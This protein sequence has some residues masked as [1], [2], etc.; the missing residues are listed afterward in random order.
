[1]LECLTETTKR[2]AKA[3]YI[4]RS[5]IESIE[6]LLSENSVGDMAV[7]K[8]GLG[9]EVDEIEKKINDDPEIERAQKKVKDAKKQKLEAEA[10]KLKSQAQKAK[11]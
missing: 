10:R 3:G 6:I 11:F 5:M 9:D 2:L 8:N 4:C 1:M 7:H